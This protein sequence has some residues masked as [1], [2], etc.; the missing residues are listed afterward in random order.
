MSI[1]IIGLWFG[2]VLVDPFG[3]FF[4]GDCRPFRAIR[5]EVVWTLAGYSLWVLRVEWLHIYATAS[6]QFRSP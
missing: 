6:N 4:V 1:S 2:L 3:L 5:C